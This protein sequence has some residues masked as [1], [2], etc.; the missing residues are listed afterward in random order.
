MS[1]KTKIALMITL[2]VSVLLV[3]HVILS[4]YAAKDTVMEELQDKFRLFTKQIRTSV[5]NAAYANQHAEELL[6]EKIRLAALAAKQSLP[7]QASQVTNEQLERLSAETGVS[8]ITLFVRTKDD[9]VGVK[10]SDP[11]EIGLG[12]KDWGY[13]YTAFEQLFDRREVTIP[14]GQKLPHYWSGPLEVSSS[15]PNYIDKW[16][17]YY[18]GTTDYIINPYVR[19][20][21]INGF[22]DRF[23]PDA[24]IGKQLDD[25]EPL[26]EVTGFNPDTFGKP[27]PV[28]KQSG[29]E[30]VLL[31]DQPVQ[32]GTYR[33]ADE[34][35][36][37]RYVREAMETNELAWYTTTLNGKRVIKGFAPIEATRA[38]VI[39][40]TV[41][42]AVV[43]QALI[44]Q[45]RIG[46]TILAVSLVLTF[47]VSYVL[48]GVLIR[49]LRRILLGVQAMSAGSIG[50]QIPVAG[51]DEVGMLTEQINAMSRNL[52]VYTEELKT[53]N[54]EIRHQAH[55]DPL[56]GLLNRHAFQEHVGQIVGREAEGGRAAVMFLDIDR[57]KSVNDLF[58]HSIGDAVIRETSAR[59]KKV[60]P[61]DGHAYRVGGDEFIVLLPGADAAMA[62]Q[63]AKKLVAAYAEAMLCG[64]QELY[65]TLSIG[66]SC[67][68]E[69][70]TNADVLVSA[71]DNAMFKAKE[72]GG[73]TYEIFSCKL[74]QAVQ[75]RVLIENSLRKA[76]GRGEFWLVYQPIVDA[77]GYAIVG[78]EALIRWRHP[79]LGVVSPMEFIPIAEET[80]H[81]VEIGMWAL[82]EACLQTKRWQNEGAEQLGI[83]VNL[84]GRQFQQ[85]DLVERME[86][87]LAET[88]LA[89]KLLTLEIT[90]NVAI[91]NE[92]HVMTKLTQLKLLGIKIAL[93]DFGT[94]YSSLSYL[95]NFPLDCLK[96]DKSFVQ[97]IGGNAGEKEIVKT[98]IGMAHGLNLKVTAEGVETEEQLAYL[99]QEACDYAQGY[100]IAKPLEPEACME[101]LERRNGHRRPK[102]G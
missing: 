74:Y 46:V 89:P 71:A 61:E 24:V 23:G 2:T 96:I 87:V 22:G 102:V 3:L 19:D 88:G 63:M 81:I 16:G 32:F 100:L 93:D 82:R 48:A 92:R 78:H 52:G 26:L 85:P 35:K 27:L 83:S 101:L 9:I 21:S 38:Y 13:W 49:P 86:A 77:R 73:G 76:L 94:G 84:S 58:G 20:N 54:D 91:H 51:K 99:K 5:E 72:Q 66:I 95:A 62:E 15:D 6:G 28:T 42:Y 8:F 1:L 59:M 47:L 67:Y 17:Y 80:G 50:L 29:Q 65:A 12:T 70:G 30:F 43:D 41:D 44:R 69:D 25:Y 37:A 79:E 39:G 45:L 34:R 10:S 57:F 11:K 90:E 68:P 7:P 31:A 98:I 18:D 64:G 40:I 97:N 53:K 4:Y 75:R 14:E 36:D 33:Y 56:T 60:L 55:H